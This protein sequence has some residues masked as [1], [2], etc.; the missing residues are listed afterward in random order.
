MP[1]YME[2]SRLVPASM[3]LMVEDVDGDGEEN[4]ALLEPDEEESVMLLLSRKE[5]AV[6]LFA[7]VVDVVVDVVDD[8][9]KCGLSNNMERM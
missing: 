6:F 4:A 7:K 9:E 5:N 3:Y 8:D 2:S 1:E